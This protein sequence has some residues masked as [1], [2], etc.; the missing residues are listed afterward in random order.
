MSDT[1]F[2]HYQRAMAHI[3]QSLTGPVSSADMSNKQKRFLH[4]FPK[5]MYQSFLTLPITT[6][7]TIAGEAK[8]PGVCIVDVGDKGR[9]GKAIGVSV[10]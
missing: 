5:Q 2:A 9:P 3:D 10:L 6:D 4:L 7:G 1:V 8:I